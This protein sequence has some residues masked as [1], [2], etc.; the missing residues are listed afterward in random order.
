MDIF[1]GI[2]DANTEINLCLTQRNLN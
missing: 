1:Q 2:A